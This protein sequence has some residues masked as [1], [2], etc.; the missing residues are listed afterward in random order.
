MVDEVGQLLGIVTEDC[1]KADLSARGTA[2]LTVG[3][4]MKHKVACLD[5]NASFAELV[6][7]FAQNAA[8]PIVVTRD[9]RPTGLAVP[10]NLVVLGRKLTMED[11]APTVPYSPASDYLVVPDICP[12]ETVCGAVK[13]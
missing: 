8:T 2:L 1:I 4:V 12:A 3:Q 13:E 5:E 9:G 7:S 11:L 6:E 10:E